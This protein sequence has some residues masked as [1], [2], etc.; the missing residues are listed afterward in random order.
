MGGSIRL[1]LVAALDRNTQVGVHPEH[2]S[3]ALLN[4][5]LISLGFKFC[6]FF[7]H[8]TKFEY[9]TPDVS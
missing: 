5:Y 8:L 6:A 3:L 9:N 2:F 4:S 7:R 1:E